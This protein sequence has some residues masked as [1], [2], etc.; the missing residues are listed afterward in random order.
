MILC[1][2]SNEDAEK[3]LA[4]ARQLLRDAFPGI[5]FTESLETEPQGMV[6]EKFNNCMAKAYTSLTYDEVRRVLKQI[7][8]ACGNSSELRQQKIV[9]MDIDLLQLNG[10][11]YKLQDWERGYVKTLFEKVKN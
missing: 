3:R 4:K 10:K 8:T 1:L 7:E 9:C 6:T 11:R 5:V 2:G